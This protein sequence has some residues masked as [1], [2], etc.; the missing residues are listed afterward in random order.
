MENRPARG[1]GVLLKTLTKIASAA[2]ILPLVGMALYSIAQ[3]LYLTLPLYLFSGDAKG[4]IG[5]LSYRLEIFEHPVGSPILESLRILAIPVIISIPIALASTIAGYLI[6]RHSL[7]PW[8]ALTGVGIAVIASGIS[9]GLRSV[10]T[11]V[12]SQ[13]ASNHSHATSAGYIVFQGVISTQTFALNMPTIACIASII[14]MILLTIYMITCYLARQRQSDIYIRLWVS[15]QCP[16]TTDEKL[17][18]DSH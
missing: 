3:L 15:R 6:R 14:S 4:Y 12:A 5:I 9:I 2:Q 1:N 16:L 10:I 8:I 7:G 18:K 13:V 11:L 17:K